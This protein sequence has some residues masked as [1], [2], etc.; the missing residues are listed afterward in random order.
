MSLDEPFP[1]D[2]LPPRLR[3][4]ILRKFHWRC[5]S[6]GEIA[7][8]SDEHWLSTLNIGRAS[9]RQI[10]SVEENDLAHPGS[11]T[12]DELLRRLVKLQTELRW[13]ERRLKAKLFRQPRPVQS[14]LGELQQPVANEGAEAN[15]AADQLLDPK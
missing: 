10:R 6:R 14:E 8:I 4:V 3:N 13:V 9:L 2:V 5:P 15:K 7:E 11:M 12:D 1:L